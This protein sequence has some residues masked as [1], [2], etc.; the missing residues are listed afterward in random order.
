MQYRSALDFPVHW[1]QVISLNHGDPHDIEDR[2][3]FASED[4]AKV[5]GR[6][7]G[8]YEVHAQLRGQ[9]LLA[10]RILARPLLE[11]QLQLAVKVAEVVDLEQPK[12]VDSGEE[13][14]KKRVKKYLLACSSL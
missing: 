5:V 11:G 10:P 13:G 2:L 6:L 3:Q 7:Q 4:L 1:R 8:P 9:L 12:L 14:E